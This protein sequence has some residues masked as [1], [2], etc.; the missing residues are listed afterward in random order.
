MK[1]LFVILVCLLTSCQSKPLS[2][3]EKLKQCD[4]RSC[5]NRRLPTDVK[6]MTEEDRKVGQCRIKLIADCIK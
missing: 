5:G 1:I 6:L 2:P 4:T 3:L